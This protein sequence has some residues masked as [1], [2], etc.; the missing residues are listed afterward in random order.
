MYIS[1]INEENDQDKILDF[2]RKNSF[3]IL[4]SCENNIPMATHIPIELDLDENNAQILRG[5][6]SKANPQWQ[7]WEQ[8]P[9]AMVIFSGAHSY[10]SSSW[11]EKENVSTWN[12]MAAHVY[13]SIR[14]VES[15]KL[16]EHLKILTNKYESNQEKPLYFE[17][18]TEKEIRTQMRGI[19][20]FEIVIERIEASAKLSQNR[21]DK[22]YKN[23]ISQLNKTD[24]FQAH[25]VAQEMSQ[26]RCLRDEII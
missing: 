25:Y 3:G 15:E 8:N 13:G 14:I 11:Y 23:I 4:V 22:D 2:I 19:V 6:V 1:K 17:D 21:N 26:L 20:G 9:K 16:Y 24:D 7:I 18:L 10:V 5:H 12:Y